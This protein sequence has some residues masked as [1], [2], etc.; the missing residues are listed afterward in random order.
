MKIEYVPAKDKDNA[1]IEIA[2]N[3]INQDASDVELNEDDMFEDAVS[4]D[5]YLGFND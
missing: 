4:D 1:N 3:L 2:S 5:N